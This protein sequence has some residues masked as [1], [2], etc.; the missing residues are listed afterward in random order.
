M[1]RFPLHLF[2]ACLLGLLCLSARGAPVFDTPA[3]SRM[4]LGSGIEF[5]EDPDGRLTLDA[6]MEPSRQWQTNPDDV[7]SRGYSG[8]AWWLRFDLHNPSPDARWLLEI[9]YAVLDRIDLFQLDADGN[10]RQVTLGD[11]LPF[12]QRPVPHRY[13]VVPIS[14]QQGERISLYLRLESASSL[15]A[16]L[17]LWDPALFY[18]EDVGRTVVQGIYFGGLLIIALYNLLV[19]LVLGE[20]SYLYYVGNVLSM[21]MFVASLNG[22]SYQFLWPSA[23]YWNEASTVFFVSLLL[24]FAWAFSGR[25]LDVGSIARSYTLL[26]RTNI[27]F[28]IIMAVVSL[29]ASYAFT[30]R[31]LL[32]YAALCCLWGLYIGI[33]AWRNGHPSARYFTLAWTILLLGGFIF[34]LNKNHIVP[35]NLFT[36]YTLQAGSLLEVLLLSFALAERINRERALRLHAQKEALDTQRSAN[37]ALEKRVA[38]RTLELQDANRKLQE[39]S[40]TDQLTG[41]KNRRHLN[42]Y[43][44]KEFARALRYQHNV[45]VLMID[46]DHFKSVND[47]YGHLTGDDC[48][49][50]IAAR[51]SREMRWPS[52]LAARY[53]GEEFCV[54]LPETGVDGALTVAERIRSKI[55]AAPMASRTWDLRLTVSIGLKVGTPTVPQDASRFVDQ[56]DAALYQAKDQGRNQVV[57]ADLPS[58][59]LHAGIT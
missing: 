1:V 54:V 34:A 25:F 47:N 38:E 26:H 4:A 7:F 16:P 56:A 8:S 43:L 21:M 46:V 40:D 17:T 51:V 35:R 44:D 41:L 11:H 9:S 22:W 48:L 53:G 57:C 36:D 42:S 32:P 30:I 58:P 50:E 39:L 27:G 59:G 28:C 20:R 52:D 5:L 14:L 49:Q 33:A 55:E 23:V 3:S 2:L 45:A 37:E 19:Y 13:F 24:L 29:T 10:R 6:A 15:Q 18:T 31:I 12:L